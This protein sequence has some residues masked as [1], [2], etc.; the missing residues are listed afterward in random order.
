[1]LK[2]W[3][4]K[5]QKIADRHLPEEVREGGKR[6]AERVLERAPERLRDAARPL[7][8]DAEGAAAAPEPS[9]RDVRREIDEDKTEPG[10]VVFGYPEDPATQRVWALLDEQGVE[11]R[12]MDLHQQP[13]AARQIAGVTGVMVPPYVFI[14]G[15]FWGGEGEVVSLIELGDLARVVAGD[16]AAISDEAR[17]IGK[18]VE[19]FDDAMSAENIVKRLRLGH[20]VAMEDLDCWCEKDPESGALRVIYEGVPRPIGDL[21]AIAEEIAR[22]VEAE[23]IEAR[24]LLE[25]EVSTF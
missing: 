10:V 22:L 3:L 15:R 19:E 16:L 8:A 12:R 9:A 23:E 5:A 21:E 7:F 14:K 1:M 18:I 17:R 20:I 4:E 25:P 13:A 6:L 11:T 2:R 24:W